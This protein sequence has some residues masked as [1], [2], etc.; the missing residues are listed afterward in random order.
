MAN[1]Q[2]VY[3]ATK[4]FLRTDVPVFKY[5]FPSCSITA[6]SG[7]S[8]EWGGLE[9]GLTLPGAAF[10]V[11]TPSEP[12]PGLGTSMGPEIWAPITAPPRHSTQGIFEICPG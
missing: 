11:R 2:T 4:G 1:H 6:S 7:H 10:P 8:T 5:G 12:H 3:R 9:L